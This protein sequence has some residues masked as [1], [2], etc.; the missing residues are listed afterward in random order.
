MNDAGRYS[1]LDGA[2][3]TIRLIE[4]KTHYIQTDQLDRLDT[5]SSC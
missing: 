5:H 4:P 1:F 2:F 3:I